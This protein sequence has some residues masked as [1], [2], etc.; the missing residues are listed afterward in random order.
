MSFF[1]L[2]GDL[3]DRLVDFVEIGD[4][5]DAGGDH[6]SDDKGDIGEVAILKLSG[7]FEKR[8]PHLTVCLRPAMR[9]NTM[10]ASAMYSMRKPYTM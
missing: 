3:G 1:C 5:G 2:L 6:P 7:W 10:A 8:R 4:V 9:L